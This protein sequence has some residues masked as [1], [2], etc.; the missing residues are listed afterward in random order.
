MKFRHAAHHGLGID[1]ARALLEEA[2]AH[3]AARHPHAQ[4]KRGWLNER[5]AWL[6][7]R[8]RG[9]HGR[10]ILKLDDNEVVVEADLPLLARPFAGRIRE[11][12]DREVR[13]WL[14]RTASST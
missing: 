9:L 3:H 4:V 2:F 14:Q 6:D 7:L 1:R 12:L 13:D 5:E 10:A 11:R 8:V